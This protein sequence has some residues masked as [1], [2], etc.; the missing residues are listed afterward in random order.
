MQGLAL[1]VI[2]VFVST[3]VEKAFRSVIAIQR[4][5]GALLTFAFLFVPE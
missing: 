5:V 1:G 4:A 3:V 2:R